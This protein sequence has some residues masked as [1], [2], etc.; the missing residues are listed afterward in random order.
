MGERHIIM[1]Q[2]KILDKNVTLGEILLVVLGYLITSI[3]SAFGLTNGVA[4]RL[5]S[6]AG[7]VIALFVF[8]RIFKGEFLGF[9]KG[10]DTKLGIRLAAFFLI[11]YT[12]IVIQTLT[13]G[14][15]DSPGLIGLSASI[16]AGV[17]EEAVFR[18]YLVTYLFRHKNNEKFVPWILVISSIVFGLTHGAN[19]FGGAP[20]D[21]TILQ[22]V[23][24][25]G[26]GGLLAAVYMRSGNI[27]IVMIAHGL[28]DYLAFMDRSQTSADGLMTSHISFINYVDLFVCACL[29]AIG[30]YLIRP[31][32]RAEIVALWNKKWMRE[33]S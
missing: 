24:T 12:Y 7:G 5:L 15:L 29:I 1:K 17:W 20:I 9:I 4:I 32:K 2:H 8:K 10:G 3:T 16:A 25:I 28:T 27:V 33:N 6:A 18:G 11:Y 30:F 31:E 13:I 26:I 14:E 19:A 21:I 22:V 23:G